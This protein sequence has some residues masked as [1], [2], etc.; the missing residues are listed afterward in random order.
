MHTNEAE[1]FRSYPPPNSSSLYLDIRVVRSSALLAQALVEGR[2]VYASGD[3]GYVEAW[4][5]RGVKGY[6]TRF[7]RF[8]RAVDSV[9]ERT[10]RQCVGKFRAF[11]R[12]AHGDS[13]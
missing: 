2:I 4:K 3:Y 12:K 1:L 8:G 6:F 10:A 7:V 13:R 9:K 5:G 11:H